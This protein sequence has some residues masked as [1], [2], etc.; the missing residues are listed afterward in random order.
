[1]SP[2]T[3]WSRFGQGGAPLLI[4]LSYVIGYL[5]NRF[6]KIKNSMLFSVITDGNFHGEVADKYME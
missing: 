6:F 3:N 2:W 4:E 1:M 5:V